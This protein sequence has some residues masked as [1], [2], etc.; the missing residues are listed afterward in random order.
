MEISPLIVGPAG[1]QL[2]IRNHDDFHALKE[3]EDWIAR[4]RFRRLISNTCGYPTRSRTVP[5]GGIRFSN[6]FTFVSV[7]RRA[8][9]P[10]GSRSSRR[11]R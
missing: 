2:G 11:E 6:L 10:P 8:Q 4:A 7:F 1:C 9:L 3:A 5:F